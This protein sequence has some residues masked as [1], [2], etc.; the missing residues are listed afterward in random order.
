MAKI[1]LDIDDKNVSTVLIILQNL[2]NGLIKNISHE[3]QQIKP[4]SSSLEAQNN[5]KYLSKEAYKN[6]LNQKVLEDEFLPRTTSARKYISPED[7]KKRLK[8]N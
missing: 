3:K 1:T 8:G 4:I 5:K 6:K 2:K 7:F